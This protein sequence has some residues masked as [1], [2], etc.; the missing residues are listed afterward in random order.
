VLDAQTV[1]PRFTTMAVLVAVAA[2]HD[3]GG[4]IA[5]QVV[6]A[7]EGHLRGMAV[8]PAWH[9]AGVAAALLDSAERDLRHPGCTRIT[10][11]TTASL[12][13]AIRFH[14]H[15]GFCA[16]GRTSYFFGMPLFEYAS[17]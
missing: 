3:I 2:D 12:M 6:S 7:D 10:L 9:G 16:S 14:E 8:L 17:T 4:T 1:D 15:H 13:R 5:S 11:D